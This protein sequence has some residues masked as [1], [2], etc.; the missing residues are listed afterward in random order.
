M[1]HME[2]QRWQWWQ[3][4]EKEKREKTKERMDW[5][6]LTWRGMGIESNRMMNQRIKRRE[7][8]RRGKEAERLMS[9]SLKA[10]F[11]PSLFVA[12]CCSMV[13][14]FHCRSSCCCITSAFH[15]DSVTRSWSRRVFP[16][17]NVPPAAT[18]SMLP[19]H[20]RLHDGSHCEAHAKP[21][22][23]MWVS[24]MA[25]LSMLSNDRHVISDTRNIFHYLIT[26]AIISNKTLK[27]LI[28]CNGK[29]VWMPFLRKASS[30]WNNFK[31]RCYMPDYS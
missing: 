4:Q 1:R 10:F 29:A 3:H 23:D 27:H 26:M 13:A 21:L 16:I 20:W 15:A 22:T 11:L 6:E 14:D 8:M 7:T 19:P 5:I 9:V 12:A 24:R 17:C 31:M 25:Q 30:L 18:C 2:K 28:L